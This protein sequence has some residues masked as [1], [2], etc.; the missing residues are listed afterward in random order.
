MAS[1]KMAECIFGATF[2]KQKLC[3]CYMLTCLISVNKS[4]S[5]LLQRCVDTFDKNNDYISMYQYCSKGLV[6][7]FD[8][9]M[10]YT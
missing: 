3:V 8:K 7:S 10:N 9:G 5:V 1:W 4:V 2:N 6:D